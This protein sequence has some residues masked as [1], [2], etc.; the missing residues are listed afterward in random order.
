[1]QRIQPFVAWPQLSDIAT[2]GS[3]AIAGQTTS[4]DFP[5]TPDALQSTTSGLYNGFVTGLASSATRPGL[6]G[7]SSY[8][9]GGTGETEGYA[10]AKDGQAN[11]VVVG[12]TQATDLPGAAGTQQP[13]NA[14]AFD[15]Y[16]AKF[17]TT[18]TCPSGEDCADIGAPALS[19]DQL[20]SGNRAKGTWSVTGSGADIWGTSDHFHFVAQDAAGDGSISARIL[21][22]DNRDSVIDVCRTH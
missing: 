9:H 14:G 21:T 17:I 22:Q 5:T 10:V 15:A 19:G 18:P 11:I 6:L 2:R 1:M 4:P 13:A 8:L 20:Y 16:V 3:A 7:Y 12:Q